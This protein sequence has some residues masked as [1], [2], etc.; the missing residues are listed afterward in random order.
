MIPVIGMAKTLERTEHVVE[1]PSYR[2]NR[3]GSS[4][5]M[6]TAKEWNALPAS[7]VPDQY[8][9]DVFKT[10]VNRLFLARHLHFLHL[11]PHRHLTP[12]EIAVKS[13][14]IKHKKKLRFLL[15]LPYCFLI[16]FVVEVHCLGI[17]LVIA[18]VDSGFQEF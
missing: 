13:L 10:R 14:S 9:L 11:R 12:G 2:T 7:M 4:S 5:L 15:L 17:F 6:R 1:M 18:T 16:N 3:F 8:N